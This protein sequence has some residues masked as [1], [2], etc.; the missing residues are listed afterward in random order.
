MESHSTNVGTSSAATVSTTVVMI[1][2]W[3]VTAL[4]FLLAMLILLFAPAS[5][6]TPLWMA[7]A[8]GTTIVGL[9]VFGSFRYQI[10]KNALTFGMLPV[11]G[12]LF[13]TWW[14]PTSDVRSAQAIEGLTAWK[15]ILSTW[16]LSWHGLDQ[17]FHADT[18][19][20]ILGLTLLVS[21]IAESRILESTAFWLL[22]RFQGR[23]L[24]TILTLT[25][26]VAFASGIL[27]GVS[28]I[29]LLIRTL[30]ILLFLVK[31]GNE[32][33]R[34]SVIIATILTTVCGIWLAYGEPPNLIMKANLKDSSGQSY[35]TDAFFLTWCLPLAVLSFA[36]VAWNL[37][38]RIG[39]LTV[40]TAEID[41]MEA[42]SATF[43]FLQAERHGKV[44]TDVELISEHKDALGTV[45][46]PLLEHIREG[47]SLGEAMVRCNVPRPLRLTLLSVLSHDTLAPQL[48]DYFVQSCEAVDARPPLPHSL[49]EAIAQESTKRHRAQRFA[50]AALAVFVVLLVGHTLDH[51]IPLFVAPFVGSIVAM[52]G[53]IQFSK[54]L[55]LALHNAYEE[56]REYYFLFPLFMSITLLTQTGFFSSL[57][58]LILSAVQHFGLT[59]VAILQF[60]GCTF[61]SAILDN[62][63]VADFASRALLNLDI[64][65]LHLFAVSQ[66]AG[67]ALGGCWT[68]IGSAQS[69]VA[70]AFIRKDV[71]PD[72]TP[73]Q[74]IAEITP[75]I[76]QLIGVLGLAIVVMSLL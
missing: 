53:L 8:L 4:L 59:A 40:K 1:N 47:Q 43:R 75:V 34:F 74:W 46:E 10:H 33:R 72:F 48:D 29:G 49:K 60:L 71:A 27:D 73:K 3:G 16:L 19:L 5:A 54:T 42:H 23:L 6:S 17:L 61:L 63:V 31:A 37:K 57:E 7:G 15:P 25:A 32:L 35:L 22:D 39:S 51:S 41:V 45:V 65:I 2:A 50:A 26:L 70:Y 62:N 11:I 36:V 21:I 66:I 64:S 28:M 76:L 9:F 56:Y 13:F 38:K 30:A 58:D 20:F 24:P 18:M 67:Y 44:Y 68:H 55:K 14:W 52:L 12:T 69:V